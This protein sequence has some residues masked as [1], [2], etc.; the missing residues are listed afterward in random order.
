MKRSASTEMAPVTWPELANLHP[1]APREQALGYQ[2]L[3]ST[4]ESWLCEITGFAAASLQPN[5]GAQGEFA[6]LM[7]IRAYLRS[8]PDA[9]G[10]ERD[11]C[12]IPVSAHGTNPASSTMAG[13]TGGAAPCAPSGTVRLARPEA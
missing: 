7:T 4:L 13:M 1:Y 6:G 12:L 11:V 5:S 2:A 10:A 8:R 3:F 9:A